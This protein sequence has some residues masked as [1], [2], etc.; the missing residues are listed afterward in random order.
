MILPPFPLKG[1]MGG[2]GNRKGPERDL[3]RD[4]HV[5]LNPTSTTSASMMMFMASTDRSSR[6]SW[7]NRYST[8]PGVTFNQGRRRRGTCSRR[9]R[10]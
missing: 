9:W 6:R 10:A 7:R 3:D 2:T 5:T 1:R 8:L 4:R